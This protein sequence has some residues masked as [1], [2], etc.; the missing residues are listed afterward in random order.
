MSPPKDIDRPRQAVVLAGGLGTRLRPFTDTMPKPMIPVNGQPFLSY[1]LTQ[2]RDNG[3]ERVLIL[4]GYR[5]ESI[6]QYYGS[7]ENLGIEIEYSITDVS[8]ETGK[9]LQEAYTKLDKFFFLL[10]CD[11]Y[12]R[13]NFDDMWDLYLTK[14]WDAQV[15]VYQNLDGLTRDNMRVDDAGTVRLYDKS[16]KSAG[17]SG[18][19][20]GFLILKRD[21][22]SLIPNGNVSFEASVYP[23]LIL[24]ENLGA[25]RSS[26]RYFS[27]GSMERVAETAEYLASLK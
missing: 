21:V 18:V 14:Q 1:L 2:L 22:L 10:Y 5:A 16:R 20:I 17:L 7:G 8:N 3:F 9:R 13:Y 27:I 11:N 4:L 23:A 12:W 24:L 25:Y 19:D 6:V 26:N 15:S